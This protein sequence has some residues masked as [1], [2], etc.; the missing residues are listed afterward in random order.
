MCGDIIH[1]AAC[2]YKSEEIPKFFTTF[3]RI[4]F[5]LGCLSRT[6]YN[7]PPLFW[8]TDSLLR[9]SSMVVFLCGVYTR[10]DLF[11][12]LRKSN[13]H[14]VLSFS[15]FFI[16]EY[17]GMHVRYY[18]KQYQTTAGVIEK[19]KRSADIIIYHTGCP[20]TIWQSE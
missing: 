11:L 8:N 20:T 14:K 9:P 19:K 17:I 3:Q 12:I 1:G 13:K 7:I 10:G 15:I 2:M 6:A 4:K 16:L 18:I 5:F